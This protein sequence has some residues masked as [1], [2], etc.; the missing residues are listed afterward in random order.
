MQKGSLTVCPFFKS[1]KENK[2]RVKVAIH[3]IIVSVKKNQEKEIQDAIVKVGIAKE[4]IESISYLKKSI[5]NRKKQDIKFVYHIEVCLKKEI[6]FQDG[7]QIQIV[8]EREE[9]RRIASS[10]EKEVYVIGCGPAGL[11]AAYR[12]VEHG[13]YPILLERGE[14][15]DERDKTTEEFIV[16]GKLNPN[17][18][19]QFGE[20]GAGT[21]SDG[22]LNTRVKSEYIEKVFS[23]LV[24]FGAPEEILWNYKPHVGTDILKKVVKNLREEIKKRGGRFHFNTLVTDFKIESGRLKGF[25]I[26]QNEREE[27]MES[28][29]VLLAIG[30]SSR[31]TYRRLRK[32]GVAMESKAFAV[33]TRMEHPRLEIDRIQYGKEVGNPL[34]EAA[35]YSLT[36]NNFQE[37]R[38]IFS[39]CMCPGGVIVNAASEEGG[40]LVNGMSYSTRD[41]K[42]SNSAVVVGVK[43]HDFGEDIF[44][45]MHFQE[46]LE[47]KT[48][49]ILGEYGALYQ[50]AWDFLEKK[51]TDHEIE[52]SYQMK[53]ESFSLDEF[54]PELITE[55]LR[56][57]LYYWNRDKSFI[58]KN[59]NLI[60]PET[61]T[62]APIK[63]IRDFKGESL[64]VK[65]LYP[66]GEG[67]GYAGGI[68]SAA[69]D[70]MKIV[71]CAFSV[72]V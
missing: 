72:V 12:L 37:K 1:L 18:N 63:I 9:F 66:I 48:F 21:Y 53:K 22:K 46:R 39:F 4:N 5:D 59:V 31:D 10:L 13:Y 14:E 25:W 45:G 43:E 57:A 42:F 15:V 32:C 71:D 65:G 7:G 38:G 55:N 70:G 28:S 58:S 52:T 56:A 64:N 24:Q 2:K 34:L 23:L 17:S 44:S 35:T 16:T 3:N 6:S 47:R 20:G 68:V 27:Y 8:E 26:R 67:A 51:R 60:A 40:S 30:H 54:F 61:R 33:G 29:Q 41:G 49:Q 19:I 36:Y 69:V 62:S 11:F 50:S